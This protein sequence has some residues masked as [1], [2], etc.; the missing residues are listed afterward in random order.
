MVSQ[1]EL[2][3]M[4]NKEIIEL[5]TEI[6]AMLGA[7]VEEVLDDDGDDDEAY[8]DSPDYEALTSVMSCIPVIPL[9][10]GEESVV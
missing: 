9:Y 3:D 6:K 5:L 8:D 2:S 4:S 10:D 1:G 7:V